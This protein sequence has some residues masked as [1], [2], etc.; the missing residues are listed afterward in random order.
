MR[1]RIEQEPGRDAF[2]SYGYRV[3]KG[4]QLVARY[5]HDYRGDDHG[6]VFVNGK[7]LSCPGRMTDFI[8]GG[9]PEPIA[10]SEQAATYLD[11]HFP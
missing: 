5:W 11:Q 9:G 4:N 8:T 7:S 10:L 3:Y 6:I 2:G 1:Y